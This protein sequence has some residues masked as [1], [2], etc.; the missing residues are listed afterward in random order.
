MKEFFR[1]QLEKLFNRTGFRQLE[2][3][4]QKPG[5]AEDGE[6][7]WEKDVRELIMF[8]V[9]ECSKPPFDCVSDTVK[10]RVIAKAV[11]DE[12]KFTGLNARFVRKALNAWWK[13]NGERVL[14][15]LNKTTFEKAELT[16]EQDEKVNTMLYSYI[17]RLRAPMQVPKMKPNEIE[18]KG[19][20][21][22]SG[23]EQKAVSKGY[24]SM[25]LEEI[26]ARELHLQWIKEN[27]HPV[28]ARPLS[29]WISEEEWL[30]LKNQ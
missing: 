14:E 3:M 29:N 16:P 7:F 19:A 5:V 24:Q 28:T 18:K 22:Q 4:M 23:I 10:M 11:V 9:E 1:N 26:K 2:N 30:K 12:E 20:E 21:W 17:Q 8:M 15:K 27:Y 6:A 13:D 25:P